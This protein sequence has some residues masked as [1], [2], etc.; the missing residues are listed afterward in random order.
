MNYW[1]QSSPTDSLAWI[2]N[3]SFYYRLLTWL[4][5]L[6]TC[7]LTISV[8]ALTTIC[9]HRFQKI[10]PSNSNPQDGHSPSGEWFSW[11]LD[12]LLCTK[13]YQN[14]WSKRIGT[15][16]WYSTKSDF[17]MLDGSYAQL[18]G[19]T[20]FRTTLNSGLVSRRYLSQVLCIVLLV[21]WSTHWRLS[22]LKLNML[23]WEYHSA[24]LLDGLLPPQFWMQPSG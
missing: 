14:L 2:Q 21:R 7:S 8:L 12:S 4:L 13:H 1:T 16:I 9:K 20:L 15:I 22:S 11:V 10:I 24:S 18:G 6:P 3:T 23:S 19:H 17:G 5:L